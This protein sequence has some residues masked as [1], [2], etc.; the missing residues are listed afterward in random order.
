LGCPRSVGRRQ[1]TSSPDM[2]IRDVDKTACSQPTQGACMPPWSLDDGSSRRSLFRNAS[3]RA[4]GIAYLPNYLLVH[5]TTP[6][7][8]WRIT[9]QAGLVPGEASRPLLAA[10]VGQGCLLCP[11]ASYTLTLLTSTGVGLRLMSRK[12]SIRPGSEET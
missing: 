5:Y 9:R 1:Q 6:H 2:D 10:A 7:S 8:G 4:R 11:R 12:G 3:C